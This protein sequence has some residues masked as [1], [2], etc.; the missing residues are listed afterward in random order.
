MSTISQQLGNQGASLADNVAQSV[1]KYFT[2]LKGTE[3]VDL[4]FFVLEEIETP[5]FKAVMEHCKYNQSRAAA[6]LGISRGT[7][8]TKLRRYFDDKYVGSREK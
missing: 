7:L 2:E 4:Y 1:Q 6:L 5:L 8:R 3:P